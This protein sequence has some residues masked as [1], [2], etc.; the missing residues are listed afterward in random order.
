MDSLIPAYVEALCQEMLWINRSVD[1]LLPIGTIYLGGGTPS[2]LAVSHLSKIL[3]QI[4][5]CFSLP[6][7]LEITLEAN[8]GTLSLE[9]L[10]E[11]RAL[12]VNRLSIGMQSAHPE[13]LRFLERNHD[14]LD[15][16]QSVA[17]AR[18]SGFLNLNLD[19]IF[20]LPSQP[21]DHWKQSLELAIGLQP[22]HFSLY[23]LTI[24]HGT[25]IANWLRKGLISEPDPDM[26]AEMYEWSSE[27]LQKAGWKQYEISN[28]SR[29][30]PSKNFACRHNLQYWRNQPYLGLGAGAHGYVNGVRTINVLSPQSYIERIFHASPGEA[31]HFPKTP[32]TIS[33]QP[34][35][36]EAEITDTM[37]M[38][39]RLVEEGISE[40][41]FNNRFGVSLTT[42]FERKIEHLVSQGLLE[43]GM[44]NEGR[45]LRLTPNGRL[46]GNLVF[47][48]FV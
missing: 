15:V 43:W 31:R 23:S 28:W 38:G 20:G 14:F 3:D 18:H 21:L 24:E 34:V 25:P 40:L 13:E 35:D 6:E 47:R 45:C 46:L 42:R 33:L 2:L 19:L 30:D 12:G 48:E 11:L 32:A 4:Q 39:L 9:Y 16:V 7:D 41:R 27:R 8:P 10:T 22:D 17:W 36:L 1:S 29:N 37:I 5:S 26:A 44:T